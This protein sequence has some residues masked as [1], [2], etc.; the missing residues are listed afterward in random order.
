MNQEF[1][2]TILENKKTGITDKIN[3]L[4]NIGF[5]SEDDGI[6]QTDN[7]VEYC[8]QLIDE[9]DLSTIIETLMQ[10]KNIPSQYDE[11]LAMQNSIKIGTEFTF[12]KDNYMFSLQDLANYPNIYDN[13]QQIN[14]AIQEIQSWTDRII[15]SFRGTKI[16]TIQINNITK[17]EGTKK[18]EGTYATVKL[19]FDLYDPKNN[20]ADTWWV[21]FDLD[22]FCI[23]L[24]TEPVTYDF[25]SRYHYVIDKCFF[26][27]DGTKCIPDKNEK[28][29]GG[30]HISLDVETAFLNEADYLKNF[31]VL[32]TYRAKQES[33]KQES[34]AKLIESKDDWNAPFMYEI[35]EHLAFLELLKKYHTLARE[36]A[37]IEWLVENINKKVYAQLH[38]ELIKQ[39]VPPNHAPHYQAVNLEHAISSSSSKGR[40]EI[41]RYEAQIN[42]QELLDELD[43]LYDLLQRGRIHL[44]L[45]FNEDCDKLTF[46]Q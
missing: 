3:M 18:H 11:L 7:G 25:Y 45:R 23:E 44:K 46:E 35:G 15:E 5:L 32:Y 37:T 8:G 6:I 24:Q 14:D 19:H 2:R 42:I 28:T 30:G 21:N 22:P 36:N 39:Q 10:Q 12:R 20:R 27:F 13:K 41:R 31:L 34:K 9:S 1:I 29:G 40:V 33:K 38:D 43:E 26:N 4:K 16:G 17:S